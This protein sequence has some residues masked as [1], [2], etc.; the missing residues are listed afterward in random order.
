MA[1]RGYPSGVWEGGHRSRLCSCPRLDFVTVSHS[2]VVG[3]LVAYR[4]GALTSTHWPPLR[5]FTVLSYIA[6][7]VVL[8]RW[9]R[10][11]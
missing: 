9:K 8:G 4:P 7:Q 6:A 5:A 1:S 3:G 11:V 10:P 2:V